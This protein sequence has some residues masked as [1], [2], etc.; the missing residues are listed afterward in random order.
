MNKEE[1]CER[2]ETLFLESKLEK[3]LI[4]LLYNDSVECYEDFIDEL[5]FR[6]EMS[7]NFSWLILQSYVEISELQK[8]NFEEIEKEFF[9]DVKSCFDGDDKNEFEF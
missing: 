1:I 6:F 2:F 4:D 7:E 3:I 9:D 5:K 8:V